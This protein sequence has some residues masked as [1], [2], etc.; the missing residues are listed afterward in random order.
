MKK[1]NKTLYSVLCLM[2]CM[3]TLSGCIEEFEADIPS[4]DSNLLV[5]EG[6]IISSRENTFI[7]T[8]TLPINSFGTPKM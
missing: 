6:T 5:V 3:C 7:L 1:L 8:R 4:E 2:V